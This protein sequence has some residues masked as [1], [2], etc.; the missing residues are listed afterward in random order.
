MDGRDYPVALARFIPAFLAT[1]SH[2]CREIAAIADCTEG[3][4]RKAVA[5]LKKLD[6]VH[7]EGWRRSVS[8]PHVPIYSN[9]PGIDAPRIEPVPKS[10]RNRRYRKSKNGKAMIRD[11][12]RREANG[13]LAR[14][15]YET[16]GVAAIDPL[17]AALMGIKSEAPYVQSI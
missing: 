17:L 8:G 10:Q 7:I 15:M 11:Q 3:A 5:K 4:A 9:G 16:G 14:K 1:G 2:T 6:L 12:R 13:R